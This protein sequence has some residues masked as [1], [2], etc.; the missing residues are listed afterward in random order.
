M[1]GVNIMTAKESKIVRPDAKGRITLGSLAQGVSSYIVSKDKYDRIILE[2]RVEIPA[3]EKWL[4]DNKTALT[5][6]KKGMEDSA[7]GRIRSRGS[8]AKFTDDE[9]TK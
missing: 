6:V 1:K 8:F 3:K 2:P 4:F 7:A 9:D 5:Q